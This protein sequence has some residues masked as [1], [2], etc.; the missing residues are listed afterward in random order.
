MEKIAIVLQ[1]KHLG[2]HVDK[3]VSNFARPIF[4]FP[5][6]FHP[7]PHRP[8][9]SRSVVLVLHSDT[10]LEMSD[11]SMEKHQSLF[12]FRSDS[13]LQ[14]GTNNLTLVRYS[15]DE[16]RRAVRKLDYTVL[17]V[18]T[19]FYLLSFLVRELSVTHIVF[20]SNSTSFKR[21]A[22]TSVRSVVLA[23]RFINPYY[24]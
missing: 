11:S 23:H 16:E 7:P 13:E 1:Y 5:Q 20:P 15:R 3:P 22:P 12:A 4:I 18:M 10:F 2:S 17:P 9:E 21:T 6:H 8:G 19:I 24:H 14:V